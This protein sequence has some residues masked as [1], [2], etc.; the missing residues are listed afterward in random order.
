MDANVLLWFI[1]GL[2]AAFGCGA[3]FGICCAG[4]CISL[5]IDEV[6][7]FESEQQFRRLLNE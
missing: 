5:E 4:S 7:E 1:L 6:E 2:T 3:L